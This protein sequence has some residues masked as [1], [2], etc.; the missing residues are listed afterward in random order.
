MDELTARQAT[1]VDLGMP[2]FTQT[3]SRIITAPA[4]LPASQ[5][6]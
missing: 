5:Q 1:A 4:V 6:T 2:A 3:A